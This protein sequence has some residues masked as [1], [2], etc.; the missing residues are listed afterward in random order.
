M[1]RNRFMVLLVMLTFFVISFVTNI[2]DPLEPNIQA[3]F[4]LSAFA[5]G[6]MPFAFFAAYGVMSIPAGMLIER[7]DAKPVLL[8]AFALA[9]LGSSVFALW[10]S[11]A[12]AL[13]S[14]FTIAVGFAML[15]VVINPLLRTSG[16]EAHYAFFGNLSQLV[17]G[18]ASFLSPHV[19]SYLVQRLK[20][21]RLPRG[22]ITGTLRR[23]VPPD[24][25]W[26]SLY[27]VFA[28]IMLAMIVVVAMVRMP[29]MELKDDERVES[30]STLATLLRNRTVWLYFIGIFCYVGT[31][32]GVAFWISKF[33]ETYHGVDPSGGG[34]SAVAGFWGLMMVGCALGLVLLK[35][36]DQR[37]ILF[38]FGLCAVA[39]LLAALFGPRAVAL[40]AFPMM[41]FWCSIMWPLIF[42]LAL[43][44]LDK[45]HGS[46][47]GILCT[48]IVGGAFLPPLIGRL[49]DAF[50]LRFGMLA[51]LATLGYIIS[52]GLWARPLISNAT[53]GQSKDAQPGPA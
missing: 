31:E 36:F 26:L 19:Y 14:L 17:F 23:M 4:Q 50:G 51:L 45:H 30:L 20:D 27:W 3:S 44:S 39:T 22:L 40:A 11:Y 34:H 35:L 13:P 2:L 12:V 25:P 43:N 38:V 47:A 24:L 41:G 10:P 32:Q 28:L 37:K 1:A 49:G 7:F 15:Q 18:A 42:A 48:A 16:G 9:F 5:V 8:A 21:P 29:R 6:L 33:L 46:F 53:L 52:I